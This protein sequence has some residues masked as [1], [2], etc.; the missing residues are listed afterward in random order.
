MNNLLFP[1]LLTGIFCYL[2][3]IE[4]PW[5]FGMSGGFYIVGRPLV[6]GLLVGLA[7]GDIKNGILWAWLCKRFLSLTCQLEVPLIVKLPMQHMVE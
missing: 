6:A 1:A 4:T 7:F 3:A 5:L 2:G